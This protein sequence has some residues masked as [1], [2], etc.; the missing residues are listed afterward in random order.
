MEFVCRGDPSGA[1][2]GLAYLEALLLVHG[3]VR[4]SPSIQ[5]HPW[6]ARVSCVI[7]DQGFFATIIYVYCASLF[8]RENAN[9]SRLF[10]TFFLWDVEGLAQDSVAS[11]SARMP[12]LTPSKSRITSQGE[13]ISRVESPSLEEG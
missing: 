10:L 2:H 9:P 4:C 3:C 7:C 6:N 13:R 1:S 5:P 12:L 11:F 8:S